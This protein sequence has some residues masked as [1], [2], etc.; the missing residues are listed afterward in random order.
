MAKFRKILIEI[1]AVQF[2]DSKEG[3]ASI[4]RFCPHAVLYPDGPHIRTS[5]GILHISPGDWLILGAQGD[6]LHCKPDIFAATYEEVT[7]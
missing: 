5:E 3:L 6:F 1:D 7:E 2:I 4:L